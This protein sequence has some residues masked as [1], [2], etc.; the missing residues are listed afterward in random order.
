M[1]FKFRARYRVLTPL[2]K[3]N[4][5]TSKI[6]IISELTLIE[7]YQKIF[8]PNFEPARTKISDLGPSLKESR[9]DYSTGGVALCSVPGV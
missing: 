2:K 9:I 6:H 7:R 1:S 4:E 8:Y 3:L 5:S